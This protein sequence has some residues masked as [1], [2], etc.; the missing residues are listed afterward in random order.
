M[1]STMNSRFNLPLP[2]GWYAVCLG[3]KLAKLEVFL[4]LHSTPIKVN[5]KR[6]CLDVK[7]QTKGC[8]PVYEALFV[9]NNDVFNIG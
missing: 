5:L 1:T 4:A 3:D 9:K 7:E 6:F 8:S 2:F